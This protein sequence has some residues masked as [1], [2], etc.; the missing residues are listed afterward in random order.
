MSY[1]ESR[2]DKIGSALN[3][4]LFLITILVGEFGAPVA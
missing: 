4:L 2:L 3:K 1:I